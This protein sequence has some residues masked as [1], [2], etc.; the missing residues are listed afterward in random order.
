MTNRPMR[1]RTVR[2]LIFSENTFLTQNLEE[3][4]RGTNAFTIPNM[5]M[6]DAKLVHPCAHCHRLIVSH[7]NTRQSQQKLN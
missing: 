2:T 5:F 1:N 7:L 3:G 4:P 6:F